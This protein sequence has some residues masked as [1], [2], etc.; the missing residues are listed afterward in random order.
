MPFFFLP[1]DDDDGRSRSSAEMKGRGEGLDVR[2]SRGRSL[3]PSSFF[4]RRRVAVAVVFERP[5]RG[6]GTAG[7]GLKSVL[8]RWGQRAVEDANER[9]ESSGLGRLNW[10]RDFQ[11]DGRRESCFSQ[12]VFRFFIYFFFL[13]RFLFVFFLFLFGFWYSK[14]RA[15]L[16]FL[17]PV[18][19]SR[20]AILW[21]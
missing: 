8:G 13:F 15:G 21:L 4:R 18:W 3:L 20:F 12:N 11:W 6:E 16:S 7:L 9:R 2:E 14:L 10:A 17:L 19:E 1:G 5:R